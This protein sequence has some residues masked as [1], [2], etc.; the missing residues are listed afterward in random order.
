MLCI[1]FALLNLAT[2][3]FWTKTCSSSLSFF[4]V[5]ILT[6]KR[7][8]YCLCLTALI[9]SPFLDGAQTPNRFKKRSFGGETNTEKR[10]APEFSSAARH[11]SAFLQSFCLPFN[12]YVMDLIFMLSKLI[13]VLM[14]DC[15][16][17]CTVCGNI[18]TR[19]PFLLLLLM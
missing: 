19:H 1:S 2:L 11:P 3:S 15:T 13:C 4:S 9:V 18:Q 17:I 8:P 6:S 5:L 12:S 10:S 7:T 16:T 14:T